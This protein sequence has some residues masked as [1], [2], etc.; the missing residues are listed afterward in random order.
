MILTTST[1]H[2]KRSLPSWIS[3]VNVTKFGH[4]EILNGR[5]HLW[6]SAIYVSV[7]FLK[8][9][10]INYAAG[11]FMF[12]V[13]KNTGIILYFPEEKSSVTFFWHII[14][15]AYFNYILN[16]QLGNIK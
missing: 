8:P 15:S 3:S 2:K 16:K 4:K 14:D 11:N 6:R 12:K 1:L 13:K 7:P 9:Q 10:R 5:L